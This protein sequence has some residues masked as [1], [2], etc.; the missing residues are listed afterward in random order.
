MEPMQN[1]RISITALV[2]AAVAFGARLM[3]LEWQVSILICFVFFALGG[4]YMTLQCCLEKL[5]QLHN[6]QPPIS[7]PPALPPRR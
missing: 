5:N 4:V 1:W 2:F 7:Q 6:Q 3:P